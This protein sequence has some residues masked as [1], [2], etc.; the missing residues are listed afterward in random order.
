MLKVSRP[1]F[2]HAK[3]GNLYLWRRLFFSLV[4]V[5]ILHILYYPEKLK[6]TIAVFLFFIVAAVVKYYIAKSCKVRNTLYRYGIWAV[7]IIFLS[8]IGQGIP[9]ILAAAFAALLIY[10]AVFSSPGRFLFTPFIITWL[11]MNIFNGAPEMIKLKLATS[12]LIYMVLF[13]FIV[14]KWQSL[15]DILWYLLPAFI[16]YLGTKTPLDLLAVNLSAV[17]LFLLYPGILPVGRFLRPVF[18]VLSVAA[19][20]TAGIIGI[21]GVL[22]FAPATERI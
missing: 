19:Y 10:E 5:L 16:I 2:K 12:L 20:F 14:K 13:L 3:S 1:P 18:I 7:Y 15:K 8:R 9:A 21:A 17:I 6:L 11:L 4:S 22:I